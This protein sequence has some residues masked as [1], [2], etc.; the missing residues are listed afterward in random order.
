MDDNVGLILTKRAYLTPRLEALY[1]ST[2]GRRLSF[3]ALNE[4]CNRTAHALAARGIGKGDRVAILTLNCPE[5]VET[6]FALAK[7]GAV[8]VPLNVRLVAR[9]LT[10]ILA[11]SG[12]RTLV[13]GEEFRATVAEIH[14]SDDAALK[15]ADWIQ[16]VEPGSDMDAF[17]L[18]YHAL[19]MA[20]S[21]D[22]PAIGASEDDILYIMY[23][24]GTTGL[25]KGVVHTHNTA[26]WASINIALTSDLHFKD[27]YI[28]AL[29]AYHVG[30][31]TPLTANVHL[32]VTSV[33]MRSFDPVKTWQLIEE[34]AITNMLAVPAMLT[35]MYQVP[36]RDR[37]D[38]GQLRWIMSGGAPVPVTSIEAF[39]DIGIEIHEVYGLTESCGPGCLISPDDARD[40]AGSAGK[41]FFHGEAKIVDADDN[42]VARGETGEIILRGRNIMKEYWNQPEASAATLRGGWLHTGD[43]A[44]MDEDGFVYIKDRLKD[45]LISGGENVYPAEIENV[46]L[47]HPMVR[48]V[49]VIGQPSAR[50]G[51]V[52]LAIV[53]PT[54]A[55]VN[56]DEILAFCLDKLARFKLPRTVEFVD[57]I[58][59][60]PTGKVLKQQLRERFPGAATE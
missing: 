56:K 60:N 36:D 17:A 14:A 33:T 37:F 45:M 40:H 16:V 10:Y 51:E 41:P 22:E 12:A 34:E 49:A 43:V 46:V 58:P 48:E 44:T 54:E 5:F 7:L 19:Q 8:V 55:A 42:E 3:A 20:E 28:L 59:R 1:E 30:A 52:P 57:E 6:F 25:P 38:H 35:F 50:W 15:V 39:G 2:S 23:T 26:I 24:S 9:E 47:G 29:P 4:S 21:T 32:G 18:D 27:R 13:Y 31:L 11:D 53:V